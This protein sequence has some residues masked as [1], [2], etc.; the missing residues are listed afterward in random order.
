MAEE[1][2]TPT[3]CE[4]ETQ[5]EYLPKERM[6][7]ALAEHTKEGHIKD[8][9]FILHDKDVYEDGTLKKP[10]WHIELRLTRGRRRSDI[11][12]W[13]CLPV[14]QIQDSKSGKYEPMLQ[15][16]IHENAPEKHQYAESE[17]TANFNYSETMQAIRDS[18]IKK[19]LKKNLKNVLR[20]SWN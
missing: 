18:R 17:V 5:I 7:S 12:S 14:R 10:H 13:F 2:A 1:K 8:W 15:Y 6:L 20:R 4:V 11:A 3:L 19:R 9:A 16:L